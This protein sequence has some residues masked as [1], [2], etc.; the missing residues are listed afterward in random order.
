MVLGLGI[1]IVPNFTSIANFTSL[2][3]ATIAAALVAM[4]MWSQQKPRKDFPPGPRGWP[5]V[6]NLLGKEI[7]VTDVFLRCEVL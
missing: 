2:T 6:G 3:I 1:A 7:C 4:F 5:L